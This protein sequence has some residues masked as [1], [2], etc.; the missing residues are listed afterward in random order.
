MRVKPTS[1]FP[2][3][4][5]QIGLMH[6][7]TSEA[8]SQIISDEIVLMHVLISVVDASDGLRLG[9]E[10]MPLSLTMIVLVRGW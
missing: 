2:D 4:L 1:V 7:F 6:E 3:Y 9:L 5:G 10:L 8:A